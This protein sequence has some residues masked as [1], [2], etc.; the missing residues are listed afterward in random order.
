MREGSR[1]TWVLLLLFLALIVAGC[2][3]SM[4]EAVLP[5]PPTAPPPPTA[6][7]LLAALPPPIPHNLE[8]ARRDCLLCHAVGAAEAPSVPADSD[9]MGPAELCSTCHGLLPEPAPPTTAAPPITHDLVGREECFMC[10]K[11]GI[12]YAPRTPDN[13]NGLPVDVCKTC[14]VSGPSGPSGEETAVPG[15]LPSQVPHTLEGRSD[16]RLCHETGVGGASQFPADHADRANDVCQV[17][18]AVSPVAETPAA[19]AVAPQVPHT[20]EGRPDCRVC[21]ET[22]AG[23]ATQFPSDHADRANDV[24]QACHLSVP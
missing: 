13:H 15:M 20:L 16:C 17:C 7:P 23:G 9:H 14:H 24:C 3:P 10:H 8:G 12:G 11:M 21:H 6:V 18:H 4:G 19:E 2:L 5:Q 1:P 22:G